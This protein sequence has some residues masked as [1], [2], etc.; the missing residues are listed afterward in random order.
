MFLVPKRLYY[1]LMKNIEDDETK[2]ELI[3]MNEKPN[4]NNY[5]ENAITFKNLQD[6]QKMNQMGDK[7]YHLGPHKLPN[8]TSV[9]QTNSIMGRTYQSLSRSTSAQISQREEML[10]VMSPARV[11]SG[12]DHTDRSLSTSTPA[13]IPQ[14]EESILP[15]TCIIEREPDTER[16]SSPER[17]KSPNKTKFST[18]VGTEWR[19]TPIVEAMTQR[20]SRGRFVCPFYDCRKQYINEAQLGRHLL[21][22]HYKDMSMRDRK[23]VK[24]MTSSPYARTKSPTKWITQFPL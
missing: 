20:N 17:S 1:S 21:R 5:I 9:A 16:S 7:L 23:T 4:T 18:P 19:E 14:Q 22:D 8:V 10:N 6:R 15:S 13:Q 24:G 2:K 11:D 12:M 3:S